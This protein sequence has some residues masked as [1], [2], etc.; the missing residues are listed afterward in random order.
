MTDLGGGV[1]ELDMDWLRLQLK[2]LEDDAQG[3]AWPDTHRHNTEVV[4][5]SF[6]VARVIEFINGYTVTISPAGAYQVSCVGAN[7]NLQEVYNNLTGPTLLPNLSAGLIVRETAV[8]GLTPQ[9][10]QDLADTK[11]AAEAAV[12]EMAWQKKVQL[13]KKVSFPNDPVKYGA[14]AGKV[15]VYDPDDD[16]LMLLGDAYE[17]AEELIPY[18]GDGMEV[19][20]K[21]VEQ[22]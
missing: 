16:T 5:A 3:M 12:V 10:S 6:S 7:H 20:G 19:Q 18:R 4:L 17:D 8:S 9:E 11:T 2:A 14:L 22:P 15:A 1:Y 13:G 21:M